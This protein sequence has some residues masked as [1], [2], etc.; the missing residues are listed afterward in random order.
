MKVRSNCPI[1]LAAEVLSDGWSLAI[2][3]DIIFG[4]GRSFRD[5]R[6]HSLEGIATIILGAKLNKLVA[7]GLLTSAADPNRRQRAIYNLT[8]KS[9]A[10]PPAVVALG[11]WGR[12]F[13]PTAPELAIHN[14]VIEDGGQELQGAFM[15]ELR[16]R[17]LGIPKPK[18]G[19]F[20]S[21][22]LRATYAAVIVETAA[23]APERRR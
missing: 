19:P 18:N 12:R 15:A 20:V 11:T 13:L 2:L 23:P 21:G 17:H 22:H 8:K 9:I 14:Q 16:E 5:I 7:E 4:D 6:G 1:N 3:R 10:L